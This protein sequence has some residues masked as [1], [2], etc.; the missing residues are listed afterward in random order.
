MAE[1]NSL[2]S[3][4]DRILGAP[5]G[6]GPTTNATSA[7]TQSGAVQYAPP[8]GGLTSGADRIFYAPTD[9]T[10]A[11]TGQ[12]PINLGTTVG[13]SNVLPPTGT[14]P[15]DKELAAIR[16]QTAL[17]QKQTEALLKAPPQALAP[18][19]PLPLPVMPPLPAPPPALPSL[20]APAAAA[21]KT[22]Y[23]V[24]GQLTT[25]TP[26]SRAAAAAPA[27]AP[28]PAPAANPLTTP[29]PG[30]PAQVITVGSGQVYNPTTGTYVR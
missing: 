23:S 29:A 9:A 6:G 19:A 7:G 2:R 5:P 16:A 14:S 22:G 20:T 10:S 11:G 26:T 30:T 1:E 25:T 17:L 15:Q 24:G 12:G 3:A 8:G 27:P 13:I 28:A 21:P 4:V 18:L